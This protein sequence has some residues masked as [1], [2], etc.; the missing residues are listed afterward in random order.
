MKT[1]ADVQKFLE[2]IDCINCGGC[3]ISAL[4]MYRWLKKNNLLKGDEKLVYL[5]KS[6]DKSEFKINSEALENPEIT[7]TSCHHACL[8]HNG[9]YI[10]SSGEVNIRCYK[11]VQ[12]V[13]I[14]EFVVKSVNTRY[15]NRWLNCW[16]K[17]FNREEK[18]V[19]DRR[20]IR[21]GHDRRDNILK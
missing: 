12:H 21:C 15:N 4:A 5:Y 10:D 13:T 9:E 1:I 7:P 2:S 14:E 20:E 19:L 3:A 18:R 17:S 11:W 8:Y 16:N 6:E